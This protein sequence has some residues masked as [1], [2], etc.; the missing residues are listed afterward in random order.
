[1][2]AWA[3]EANT[4]PQLGAQR[5]SD[6]A[7]LFSPLPAN[8]RDLYSFKI[9]GTAPNIS[10][11][12]NLSSS[13]SGSGDTRDFVSKGTELDL[14]FNPTRHWRL[15]A[16][17]SKQETVQSNSFPFTRR[18]VALMKPVWDKL[19]NTPKSNYPL[20][21]Q[22]GQTL[23][24]NVQTLNQWLD[25]NIYVPLTTALATD[26]SASAEQRKWR[27]NLVGTYTFGSDSM[28]GQRLKGFG[29]G[30]AFRWQDKLGIGY[31]ATR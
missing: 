29:V 22:P 25:A 30:G 27:A 5:T 8:Y 16:N 4:N 26:G 28:F 11:S 1:A 2:A 17:V 6:I 31:P 24:A 13:L 21:F 3:V 23:P 15:L 18:F 14:V 9:N 10:V 19:G 12:G 7:L 20:G